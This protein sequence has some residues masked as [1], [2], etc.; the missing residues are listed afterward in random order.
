[1]TWHDITW[2]ARQCPV[3]DYQTCCQ[4]PLPPPTSSR[5]TCRATTAGSSLTSA[6][7]TQTSSYPSSTWSSATC[8]TTPTRRTATG[9]WRS[10]LTTATTLTS[11]WRWGFIPSKVNT[12]TNDSF[13]FQLNGNTVYV[14]IDKK[15]FK[16]LTS[17]R[18]VKELDILWTHKDSKK[19]IFPIVRSENSN[20]LDFC[21]YSDRSDL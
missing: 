16:S 15:C 14:K 5:L 3:C 10:W 18:I 11:N 19:D 2:Q 7:T 12:V 9:Q 1:M 17:F 21:G 13:V 4:S 6:C 20:I 8:T